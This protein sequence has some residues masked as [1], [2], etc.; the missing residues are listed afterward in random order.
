MFIMG[1]VALHFS[2]WSNGPGAGVGR[3]RKKPRGHYAIVHFSPWVLW[4][5]DGSNV[6]QGTSGELFGY[7]NLPLPLTAPKKTTVGKNVPISNNC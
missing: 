6:K 3:D 2:E 7:E 4:R 5:A 1:G